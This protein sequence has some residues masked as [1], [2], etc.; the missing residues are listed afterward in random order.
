MKA[1]CQEYRNG[2]GRNENRRMIPTAFSVATMVRE[3]MHSSHNAAI[4]Y[5]NRLPAPVDNQS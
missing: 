5:A 4:S 1:L 2:T 3:T